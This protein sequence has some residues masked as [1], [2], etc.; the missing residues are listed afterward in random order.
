MSL[1]NICFQTR[2]SH[3][4]NKILNMSKPK[5][6]DLVDSYRKSKNKDLWKVS[7][8]DCQTTNGDDRLVDS[9]RRDDVKQNEECNRLP[10]LSDR[11]KPRDISLKG[12]VQ[13]SSVSKPLKRNYKTHTEH[14]DF[15]A[16]KRLS[17][18][19]CDEISDKSCNSLP[20][21]ILLQNYGLIL[22]PKIFVNQSSTNLRQIYSHESCQ[23]SQNLTAQ[24]ILKRKLVANCHAICKIIST[25]QNL[26]S[27]KKKSVLLARNMLQVGLLAAT[28]RIQLPLEDKQKM[29]NKV[30]PNSTP[31]N[32]KVISTNDLEDFNESI[33]NSAQTSKIEVSLCLRQICDN[34]LH[35]ISLPICE[36]N[37]TKLTKN[38]NNLIQ[39]YGDASLSIRSNLQHENDNNLG[40]QY[41][42][43]MKIMLN[44]VIY[45]WKKIENYKACNSEYSK[46]WNSCVRHKEFPRQII[47]LDKN[48][49]LT[50]LNNSKSI[51]SHCF[52]SNFRL[53]NMLIDI[54]AH[55]PSKDIKLCYST[56]EKFVQLLNK[57]IHYLIRCCDKDFYENNNIFKFIDSLHEIDRLIKGYISLQIYSIHN[58]K[59][60]K[61]RTICLRT[62]RDLSQRKMQIF[63]GDK[64]LLT[65]FWNLNYPMLFT[66]QAFRKKS[67]LIGVSAGDY[68]SAYDNIHKQGRMP[69]TQT[70][71]SRK[72]SYRNERNVK[73]FDPYL[74][75]NLYFSHAENNTSPIIFNHR[76]EYDSIIATFS[77]FE[78]TAYK[79]IENNDDF[80]TQ[81]PKN[82]NLLPIPQLSGYD[83]LRNNNYLRNKLCPLFQTDK[84]RSYLR[85]SKSFAKKNGSTSA[86]N[87]GNILSKILHTSNFHYTKRLFNRQRK[88][89]NGLSKSIITNEYKTIDHSKQKVGNSTHFFRNECY[90]SVA[91]KERDLKH[92]SK[93][94]L[95][96][97]NKTKIYSK[98][99]SNRNKN[100]RYKCTILP[101]ISKSQISKQAT[102][103]FNFIYSAKN[104]SNCASN[105]QVLSENQYVNRNN[106]VENVIKRA[107]ECNRHVLHRC[108]SVLP[109]I[110]NSSASHCTTLVSNYISLKS[111][112]SD[113]IKHTAD[114][115]GISLPPILYDRN[116]KIK[117][118]GLFNFSASTGTDN[119]EMFLSQRRCASLQDNFDASLNYMA[120]SNMY[121]K[122][123]RNAHK[124]DE[125]R[126]EERNHLRFPI[127]KKSSKANIG[128]RSHGE[129]VNSDSFPTDLRLCKEFKQFCTFSSILICSFLDKRHNF[130]CFF[131][132]Y[133]II[134]HLY[135][136]FTQLNFI[137]LQM[138]FY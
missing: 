82:I 138:I 64:K 101:K 24:F 74:S 128:N 83:P 93:K 35:K 94:T 37:R 78:T 81:R 88:C 40:I 67:I 7:G 59:I 30:A 68:V 113:D 16:D 12:D 112:E 53:I 125:F 103:Q 58:S 104:R 135:T 47:E 63:I 56:F 44:Y 79:A 14:I 10:K 13:F 51:W 38:D 2:S 111:K 121:S 60:G 22:S 46:K 3:L 119:T 105:S 18:K 70:T 50:F 33:Q 19:Y 61:E 107:Q 118:E 31:S 6:A 25:L 71:Q 8:P 133:H 36:N 106:N 98:N 1:N 134:S 89:L 9:V 84:K 95:R 17:T 21:S 49:R 85:F 124:D 123:N 32:T 96:E 130:L 76:Q 41:D 26:F 20:S 4:Q 126:N 120:V 109:E 114:K 100:D 54:C 117:T 75:K 80:N 69:S 23:G 115:C 132:L 110:A 27:K 29:A 73:K 137:T 90:A 116:M 15:L 86:Y 131:L 87:K 108:K 45:R 42:T 34:A 62:N 129:K 127:M 11:E 65:P 122:E 52:L 99:C 97:C 28:I 91:N 43:I 72:S 55:L 77:D 39:D 66:Q 48:K 57:L 92:F 102:D 136:S 5:M